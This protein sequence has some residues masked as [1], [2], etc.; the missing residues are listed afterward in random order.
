MNYKKFKNV[1]MCGINVW[2]HELGVLTLQL[3][4]IHL[5]SQQPR[6]Y[7][8]KLI[9]HLSLKWV[10]ESLLCCCCYWYLRRRLIILIFPQRSHHQRLVFLWYQLINSRQERS[11]GETSDLD[12]RQHVCRGW[13]LFCTTHLLPLDGSGTLM[14]GSNTQWTHSSV[15]RCDKMV[16]NCKVNGK[17]WAMEMKRWDSEVKI[18]RMVV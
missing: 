8:L 11:V 14:A 7:K 4:R 5:K 15:T 10:T 2:T 1:C 17:G 9:F 16:R 12:W 3:I 18:G 6:P 13:V